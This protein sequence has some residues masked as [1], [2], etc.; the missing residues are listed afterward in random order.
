MW[1]NRHR[2]ESRNRHKQL[3]FDKSNLEEKGQSFHPMIIGTFGYPHVNK[4]TRNSKTKGVLRSGKAGGL[5]AKR[6]QEGPG[7]RRA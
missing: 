7:M 6:R 1:T 2:I 5:T 4:Q 3:I